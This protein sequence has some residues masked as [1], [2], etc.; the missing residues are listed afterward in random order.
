MSV[1]IPPPLPFLHRHTRWSRAT[2]QSPSQEALLYGLRATRRDGK[3]AKASDTERTVQNTVTGIEYHRACTFPQGGERP[4]KRQTTK[5][6]LL[7]RPRRTTI[8]HP[9]P[10]R[11][12]DGPGYKIANNESNESGEARARERTQPTDATPH[13]AGRAG[14]RRRGWPSNDAYPSPCDPLACAPKYGMRTF[15]LEAE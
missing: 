13:E 9:C 1:V 5:R 3:G 7:L 8:V 15:C 14:A 6:Y 11:S 2:P 4:R 12:T 10:A